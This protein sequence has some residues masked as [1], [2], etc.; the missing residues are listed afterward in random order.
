VSVSGGIFD[1]GSISPFDSSFELGFD[2]KATASDGLYFYVLWIS[3]IL[4]I[5]LVGNEFRRNGIQ[6]EVLFSP[7]SKVRG[8]L[9]SVTGN[10]ADEAECSAFE[11]SCLGRLS[12]CF[13][14]GQNL[15]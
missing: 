7:G 12:C 1:S 15:S 9:Y 14:R 8:C 3:L 11:N 5:S 4:S 13:D 2:S 10:S 6:F